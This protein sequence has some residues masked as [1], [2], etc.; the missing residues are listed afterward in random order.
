[1]KYEQLISSISSETILSKEDTKRVIDTFVK[2]ISN[3]IK[4][5]NEIKV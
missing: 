3:E 1:M 2:L 5:G 4:K